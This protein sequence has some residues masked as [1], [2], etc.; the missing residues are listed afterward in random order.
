MP[1]KQSYE[2]SFGNEFRVFGDRPLGVVT[3]FSY[4]QSV[5]G[6]DGGTTGRYL[7]L[8]SGDDALNA[9][10]NLSDESMVREEL[11]GGL[12]NI[13]FRPFAGMS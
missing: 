9:D 7:L 10:L 4:D 3:S 2:L 11:Y 5:S 1:V 12:A 13:S 6:Y 8:S